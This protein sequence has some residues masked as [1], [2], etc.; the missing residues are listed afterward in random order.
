MVWRAKLWLVLKASWHIYGKKKTER[1]LRSTK[2]IDTDMIFVSGNVSAVDSWLL[3]EES[4][5]RIAVYLCQLCLSL[6]CSL[7]QS[8]RWSGW[9]LGSSTRHMLCLSNISFRT[10]KQLVWSQVKHW[11]LTSSAER[12]FSPSCQELFLYMIKRQQW[13]L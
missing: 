3:G 8:E 1:P 7:L 6:C 2:H 9:S 11:C 10:C 4:G 13:Q 12:D 5:R